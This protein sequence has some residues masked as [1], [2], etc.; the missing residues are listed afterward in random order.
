MFRCILKALLI[1]FIKK[2]ECKQNTFSLVWNSTEQ[3]KYLAKPCFHKSFVNKDYVAI[4]QVVFSHWIRTEKQIVENTWFFNLFL[5]WQITIPICLFFLMLHYTQLL[6]KRSIFSNMSCGNIFGLG[7]PISFLVWFLFLYTL[8]SILSYALNR[9]LNST[10][11]W[12]TSAV[13]QI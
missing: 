1:F 10:N 7:F 11:A 8:I 13:R 6:N 3:K 12:R 4:I 9:A 2:C 5:N